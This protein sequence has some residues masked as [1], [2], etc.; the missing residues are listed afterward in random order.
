MPEHIRLLLRSILVYIFKIV[1]VVI[2]IASV[3]K[4]AGPIP[5]SVNTKTLDKD[6][7]FYVSDEASVFVK[8]DIATVTLAIT[9]NS[10]KAQEAKDT[11]NNVINKITEELKKLGV[12][13]ENIKTTGFN[14]YPNYSNEG[15]TITSYSGNVSL[16]VK[17]KDLER[18]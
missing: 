15:R 11:A 4:Y 3:F 18:I 1:F 12:K 5:L 13:E 7:T 16:E 9:T 14:I 10:L 6:T 2:F 8:P 17:E